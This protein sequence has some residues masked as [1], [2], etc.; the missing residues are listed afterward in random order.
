MIAGGLLG[1]LISQAKT[2]LYESSAIF[3]V[4]IDYAQTGALTDIQEDQA[5]R[6][7][8]GVI[9][10]DL[11][12]DKALSQINKESDL[13]ISRADFLENSFL[14]REEFR[15]TLRY[16]DSDPK[17][18]EMAVNAWAKNAN[19][20]IQEGLKHSLTSIVL[21]DDLE[22]TKICLFE[23]SNGNKQNDC[24][25]NDFDSVVNSINKISAQIQEEKTASLGLFNALS[26]TLVNKGVSSQT[27]VL[28]LRN[29]MVISGA[30]IGFFLSII[31]IAIEEMKRSSSI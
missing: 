31:I 3:S 20:I 11:V 16:R 6:G 29:L 21:L 25:N 2:P 15:W 26:V 14:D 4:T 19:A 17:N 12:I 30:L 13:A 7:V 5:M 10:S 9:F 8:G 22:R 24:G 23:F 27:A 28:G 1:F 18:A